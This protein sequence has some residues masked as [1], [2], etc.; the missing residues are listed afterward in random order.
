MTHTWKDW[1]VVVVLW[2]IVTWRDLRRP[3]PGHRYS[4]WVLLSLILIHL[5]TSCLA[6]LIHLSTSSWSCAVLIHFFL[7]LSSSAIEPQMSHAWDALLFIH[8]FPAFC[9]NLF[10]QSNLLEDFH[11][12][13]PAFCFFFVL[14]FFSSW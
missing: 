4:N 3:Q 6:V 1:H 8:N 2:S 12:S 11:F 7:V 10:G 5:S 9:F 14:F 13:F